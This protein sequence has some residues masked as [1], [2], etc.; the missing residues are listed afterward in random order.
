VRRR[1]HGASYAE[2]IKDE[3]IG[4]P[5]GKKKTAKIGDIEGVREEKQK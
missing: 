5:A 2:F 4:S 1:T 3:L